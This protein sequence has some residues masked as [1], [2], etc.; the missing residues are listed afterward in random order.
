LEVFGAGRSWL[1]PAWSSGPDSSTISRPKPRQWISTATV[2]LIEWTF[3]RGPARLT[4]SALLLR[5]RRL[6]LLGVLAEFASPAPPST[7]L[8]VSR[9]GAISAVPLEN[10]RAFLLTTPEKRASAQVVP[11]G[12]PCLS[13]ASERGAFRLEE[14]EFVLSATC[15][16][17]R[18]WLPLLVSWDVRRHRK[19]LQWRTLTVSERSRRVAPDRAFA[20][21]VSWGRK[22]TYVIYRS[23][24]PPA[25]R[26]FLGHQ[27][28][29][30]FLVGLF[31]HEGELKPLFRVD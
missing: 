11:V 19:R 2:D 17:R 23:L 28:T 12:L 26:A 31:T 3:R 16:G 29:A 7:Q 21:R 4:Q 15:A 25:S 5:G 30:R 6:A 9:P 18:T 22:E 24:G 20:A 8:R 1:G 14:H 13:Y 10:T 27:T